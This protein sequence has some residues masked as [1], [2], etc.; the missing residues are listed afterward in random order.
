MKIVVTKIALARL[1][2]I[3]EYFL[4]EFGIKSKI[5]F[6]SKF[7]KALEGLVLFPEAYPKSTIIKDTYQMVL[8]KHNTM[9]Y[10][11]INETIVIL[12][13]FDTRQHPQKLNKNL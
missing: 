10:T 7:W 5:S 8:T 4:R 2:I 9:Y 3:C 11:V 1:E 12:S 13:I 6:E